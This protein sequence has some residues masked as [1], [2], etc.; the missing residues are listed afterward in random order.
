MRGDQS[1]PVRGQAL[2]TQ[3]QGR[4]ANVMIEMEREREIKIERWRLSERLFRV[5]LCINLRLPTNSAPPVQN[6]Y[7]R[8]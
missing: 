5:S 4:L 8:N 7:Q 6:I 2:Q 1:G 3:A